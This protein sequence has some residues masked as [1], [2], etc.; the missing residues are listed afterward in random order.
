MIIAL[1]TLKLYD[2]IKRKSYIFFKS[3]RSYYATYKAK[4]N[5][6]RILFPATTSKPNAAMENSKPKGTHMMKQ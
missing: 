6:S 2:S 4:D 1:I 5:V 3:K